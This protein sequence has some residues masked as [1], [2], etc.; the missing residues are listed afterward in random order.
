MVEATLLGFA[1]AVFTTGSFI[2][3]VVQSWRTRHTRDISLGTYLLL[4]V[5]NLLWLAYGLLL[6]DPPLIVANTVTLTLALSILALKIKH[7]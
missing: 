4:V 3:Q 7:G 2:P 5:G 1:A 6:K